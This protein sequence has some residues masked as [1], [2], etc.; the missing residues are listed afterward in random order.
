VQISLKLW[1]EDQ[2][3]KKKT[4]TASISVINRKATILYD[5]WKKHLGESADTAP[6]FHA[7]I[8]SIDSRIGLSCIILN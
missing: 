6:E 8:G 3:P 4:I 5:Y 7:K 2:H 1:I